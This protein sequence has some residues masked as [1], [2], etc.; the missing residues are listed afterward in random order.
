MNGNLPPWLQVL[1]P[2]SPHF[3]DSPEG[4]LHYVDEGTGVPIV[5]LHGN[6]TWSFYYRNLI[7]GLRDRFRCLALDHL[8]CGLSDKPQSARY[9]LAGHVE[10]ARAWID[11][12]GIQAFHLVVHD[13]GGAIGFGLAA[14]QPEKI[15]SIQVLNTAAFPFPTIPPRIAACRIP[16]IGKIGVRGANLFAV[17]ATQLT[18]VTPLPPAVCDGYLYPYNNW[19]N[20]VAIH[21]FVKDIPMNRFH[22]SWKTLNEIAGSL[23]QWRDR[24]VQLLWGMQD[25]CFHQGILAEWQRRLPNAVRH[26]FVSAGHYILEDAGE[27]V[28]DAISAHIGS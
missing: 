6:P 8:G 7:A 12:L 22:R 23:Q 9:T 26:E 20:R 18:T 17:K 21:A 15:L 10:R 4:K 25:W 1:F 2:Y 5:F 3:H 13:W 14:A 19:A 27:A 11:S 24:P 28:M 16:V